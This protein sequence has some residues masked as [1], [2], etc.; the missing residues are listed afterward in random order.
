M[1]NGCVPMGGLCYNGRSDVLIMYIT[2]QSPSP[3]GQT[4]AWCPG[5]VQ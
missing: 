5:G 3:T 1:I 2:E 4:S